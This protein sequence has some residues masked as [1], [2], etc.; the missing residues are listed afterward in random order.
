MSENVIITGAS[1]GIGKYIAEHFNKLGYNLALVALKKNELKETVRELKNQNSSNKII[2]RT[3]DSSV[4]EEVQ[5]TVEYFIKEFNQIHILINNAGMVGPTGYF[6]EN[7]LN[8]WKRTIEVNLFG[9]ATYSY[10]VLKNM[11]RHNYGRIVNILGGG[12]RAPKPTLSSYG[13]SKAADLRF[14][15]SVGLEL[16][17]FNIKMNGVGPGVVDTKLIWEIINGKGV[18]KKYQEKQRNKFSKKQNTNPNKLC[19]LV[20]YLVSSELNE[21]GKIFE[22]NEWNESTTKSKY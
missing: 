1:R 20:K 12:A 22:V 3:A 7:D 8:L 17:D 6:W 5:N 14:T 18:L 13:T 11:I 10:Y 9:M 2:F 15:T 19:L 16:N 21:T 4:Q